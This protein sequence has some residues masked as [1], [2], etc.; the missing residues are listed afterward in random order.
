MSGVALG[1]SARALEADLLRFV[2]AD[3]AEV[4]ADLSRLARPLRLVVP[5]GAL[6][7]HLASTLVDR[8]GK[9]LLGVQVQTLAS[10]A[11]ELLERQGAAEEREDLFPILV[12]RCARREP[13]LRA[14]LDDLSDGYGAVQVSVD[15]LLDA[16]FTPEHAEALDEAL[17]AQGQGVASPERALVRV[18]RE[19]AS[20]LGGELGSH[21]SRLFTRALEALE[22]EAGDALPARAV[23]IYGFSDATGVQSDLLA[24]LVRDL[25]AR[26]WLE[27]PRDPASAQAPARETPFGANL[28]ERLRAAARSEAW[29][30]EIAPAQLEIWRARD[31][32]DEARSVAGALRGMLDAG[33]A[34]ERLAVVARDLAPYRLALRR[35]LTSLAVPFSGFAEPGPVSPAGRRFGALLALLREGESVSAERWLEAVW[36]L[37]TATRKAVE[38]APALSLEQSADLRHGLHAL[39]CASLGDAARIPAQAPLRLGSPARL[40]SDASGRIRVERRELAAEQLIALR[41]AAGAVLRHLDAWP[42]SAPQDEHARRLAALV[43]DELGWD[44]ETP[45]NLELHERLA[46]A[47]RAVALERAEFFDWLSRALAGELCAPLGGAGGG[48]HVL[49]VMEARGLV[50]DRVFLLGLDRGV[51]PRPIREDPLLPDRAR[52]RL[53]D[54]LPDLPVKREGFDEERFLFAQC[55][56][57]SASVALSFSA[58]DAEGRALATSPLVDALTRGPAAVAVRDAPTPALATPRERACEAGLQAS[59]EQFGLALEIALEASSAGADAGIDP[60]AL[61]RARLAVLGELDPRDGRRRAAGPYLGFVGRARAADAR[62][63]AIPVTRLEDLVRCGWQ[64]FLRKLLRLSPAADAQGALPR[65][66][67]ARLLGNAVHRA[68][69]EIAAARGSGLALHALRGVE[70]GPLD[71]PA[72]PELE[73]ILLRAAQRIVREEAIALTSFAHAPTAGAASRST[74]PRPPRRTPGRPAGPPSGSTRPA[75]RSRCTSTPPS[76]FSR[77]PRR[78]SCTTASCSTRSA[79]APGRSKRRA[80][81]ACAHGTRAWASRRRARASSAPRAGRSRNAALQRRWALDLRWR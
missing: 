40:A 33:A 34:P 62:A 59:R 15:D 57:S 71:W 3:Q 37:P 23:A 8:A 12:R 80:S 39:G 38:P 6:R 56:A 48:V 53:R 54:V 65:G 72:P 46:D 10:V 75:R 11:R 60:G 70:A 67:D 30:A 43:R 74:A 26:V 45:A 55:L 7:M 28:R 1:A 68:L 79:C 18:A 69:E 35:S 14:A 50:F 49:S 2:E 16:G 44:A 78:T 77:A 52:L 25:G 24:A 4:R 27:L 76:R 32:H 21:R 20:A 58:W 41:G 61:A 19:V 17:G 9:A 13:A 42:A 66:G 36:R 81:S 64:T 63:G 31:P 5:S 29:V 51:F 22:R 47:R 73:A